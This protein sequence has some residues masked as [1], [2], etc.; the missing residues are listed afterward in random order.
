MNDVICTK[1]YD[2]PCG[3]LVLGS[4]G[5]RLCLCDWLDSKR[6]ER[7]DKRLMRAFNAKMKEGVSDVLNLATTELDEYFAGHRKS[8]SV[9]FLLAGTE[10]QTSVWQ[11][12]CEISFGATTTYLEIADRIGNRKGVRAVAQAIG[13][14]V[15]SIIVPCHRVIGANG[16]LTGYAGGLE[17]KKML[18]K[19]EAKNL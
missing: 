5:D 9:P 16:N 7:N 4:I 2:S 19:L 3:K 10:F 18:L 6:R 15:I 12:L 17:A 11:A 1:V 8:F 13:S 14:N